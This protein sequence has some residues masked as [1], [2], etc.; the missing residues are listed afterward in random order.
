MCQRYVNSILCQFFSFVIH[1]S[2]NFYNQKSAVD[3]DMVEVDSATQELLTEMVCSALINLF[4]S[5][6]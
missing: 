1:T 6:L 4:V 3:V 5:M 2:L